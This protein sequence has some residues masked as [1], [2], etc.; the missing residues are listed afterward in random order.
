MEIP[1]SS[2]TMEKSVTGAGIVNPALQTVSEHRAVQI[3]HPATQSTEPPR[4]P[5]APDAADQVLSNER[6]ETI[7]ATTE[8]DNPPKNSPAPPNHE[9][10]HH[11]QYGVA[12]N[13]ED[14][15]KGVG[16]SFR[17]VQNACRG[18]IY[19]LKHFKSLPGDNVV[20]KVQ[21][22]TTRDGRMLYLVAMLIFVLGMVIAGYG[23]GKM[24]SPSRDRPLVIGS[25]QW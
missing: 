20:Q 24:I 8:R 21:F 3:D 4:P 5:S 10:A 16:G 15:L 6:T 11:Q 1:S 18:T 14:V 17:C 22:A 12:V 9:D 2:S 19:D 25:M 23:L 13:I 7:P